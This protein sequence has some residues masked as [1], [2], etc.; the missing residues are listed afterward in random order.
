[1]DTAFTIAGLFGV[2][3]VITAYMGLQL[4]RMTSRSLSYLW[5]NL[6][7]SLLIFLSLIPAWNLPSFVIECFWLGITL[8]G[9]WRRK[10]A[11][12]P[13]VLGEGDGKALSPM[14]RGLGEGQH[15]H[16]WISIFL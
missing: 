16:H 9:F 4:E 6:I 13:L 11:L 7:G 10:K 5:L 8:Y 14:G 15:R 12:P 3:M 2:A 1:M